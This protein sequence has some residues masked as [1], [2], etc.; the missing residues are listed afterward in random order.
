MTVEYLKKKLTILA[1]NNVLNGS[2]VAFG[3][4]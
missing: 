3:T 4:E 2:V 1:T